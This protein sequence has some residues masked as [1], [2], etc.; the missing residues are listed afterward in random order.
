VVLGMDM[1]MIGMR[2]TTS[3]HRVSHPWLFKGGIHSDCCGI[4]PIRDK[5]ADGW[6]TRSFI[7]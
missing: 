3:G 4:P 5:A 6:G 7:T 2:F 1:S